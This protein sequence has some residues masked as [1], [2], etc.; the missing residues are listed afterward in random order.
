MLTLCG[1]VST[2][3]VF[4]LK[5]RFAKK[6]AQ[7]R[8]RIEKKIRDDKSDENAKRGENDRIKSLN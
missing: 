8:K 6:A 3:S 1:K 7:D 5:N 2:I 4:Q